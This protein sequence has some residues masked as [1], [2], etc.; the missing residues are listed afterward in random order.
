MR[1]RDIYKTF[2]FGVLCRYKSELTFVTLSGRNIPRCFSTLLMRQF[3][4]RMRDTLEKQ[5]FVIEIRYVYGAKKSER[6]ANIFVLKRRKCQTVKI[7]LCDIRGWINKTAIISGINSESILEVNK[8]R[9]YL[10]AFYMHKSGNK[11]EFPKESF[12]IL[13][14]SILCLNICIK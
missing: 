2:V 14:L 12:K 10:I 5:M 9:T 11:N 4:G 13:Q 1:L 7:Y 8:F 6:L 3:L